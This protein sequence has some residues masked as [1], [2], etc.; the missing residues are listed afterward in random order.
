MSGRAILLLALVAA[1]GLVASS[2]GAA[3]CPGSQAA[4][5]AMVHGP[6]LEAPDGSSLCVATG[7]A[8]AAWIAVNVAWL[9]T[10]RSALMAAAFGRNATCLIGPDG[11]GEC[12]IEGVSLA[13][14]LRQPE[15][16]R[17]AATWR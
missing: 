12:A 13:A 2:A 4:P 10:T 16:I 1:D 11:S 7:E 14:E 9:K 5:G 17:A 8:P 6:V 15:L 3:P